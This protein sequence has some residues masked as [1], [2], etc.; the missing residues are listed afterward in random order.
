MYIPNL[1]KCAGRKPEDGVE[2]IKIWA[3]IL[4]ALTTVLISSLVALFNSAGNQES[5]TA[6]GDLSGFITEKTR[7]KVANLRG[8]WRFSVGDDP[9]WAEP[10]FDASAWTLVAAPSLWESEG[11]R[12]YDGYAW[13]RREFSVSA[14]DAARPLFVALGRIDDVDAVY[15][16]GRLI[17]ATGRFPPAYR[18][19]WDRERLYRIP[20]GLIRSDAPNVIAARVFDE[21][22]GGGIASGPLAIYAS[23]LPQPL[24][25]LSGDWIFN[26]GD[27]P[28][29]KRVAIDEAGFHPIRVPMVWERDG[30]DAYNGYAWYRKTF[31]GVEIPDTEQLVLLLGKIDDTDEVFL[32]GALI[33]QTG[34][35]DASDRAEGEAYY[36]MDR[37][38]PFSASLL[39]DRNV[40]AVR[41][42]DD[43]GF[44][45][46]YAGPVGIMT[47]SSYA[48][49]LDTLEES[50]KWKLDDLIDWLLG[51]E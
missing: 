21:Q 18:T 39:R 12:N 11:Y 41:V 42:H 10:G 23:E 44:G 34:K 28:D 4:G 37:A 20:A 48:Q 19:A 36:R 16:N 1:A 31:D 45:G 43:A 13:Y 26:T 49:Y 9:R 46:I 7:T 40:I 33:G 35:L 24:V 32:N 51:R 14:E 3:P 15:V 30:W 27:N 17:G 50:S 22:Q 25:D 29:W 5:P 6:P 38:Y 47:E 2:P 8:K